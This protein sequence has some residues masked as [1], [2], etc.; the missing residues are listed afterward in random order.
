MSR[1]RRE[2][3]VY[4]TW[5]TLRR[6]FGADADRPRIDGVPSPRQR[7][8]LARA[9]LVDRLDVSGRQRSARSWWRPPRPADHL[10][11]NVD[12][13]GAARVAHIG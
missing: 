10:T 4:A 9:A 11:V 3:F 13:A 8:A 2:N 12:R 1:G 7:A 5:D 6:D